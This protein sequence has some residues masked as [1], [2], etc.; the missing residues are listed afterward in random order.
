ME[1]RR[2]GSALRRGAAA[3]AVML[4][5]AAAPAGAA[6][7]PYAGYA[8]TYFTGEGFADGEQV[9][10]ALSQ[11]NDPLR[12]SELNGGRPALTSTLGENGVRDPF[13]VR[14]PDGDRFFLIATDLKIHGNGNWDRAQRFGSRSIMVWESTDLVNWSAQR[15]VQVS[16]P[17]AGNT[18]APEAFWDRASQRYVVFWASALYDNPEHSGSSYQRIMYA[19]TRDFR[20]FSPARTYLDPGYAVIDTTMIEHD[21][22]IY[23]FTKDER[24]N[25]PATPNGKFVF[26]DVGDSVFDSSFQRVTEGIG[27]GVISRGEGPTV[28]KSNTEEKWYLFIDEFGGR[29][30]VPFE[31]TDLDSGQ[32]TLSPDYQLPSRPR[33]GT[34]LPVTQLETDRLAVTPP[35]VCTRTVTGHVA[36]SLEVSSGVTC[37]QEADVDGRVTVSGGASLVVN[38]GSVDGSLTG[39]GAGVVSVIGATL[40]GAVT[41]DGTTDWLRVAASRVGG[42]MSVTRS[43]G[44]VAPD[45]S[46]TSVRGSLSCAGNATAPVLAGTTVSGASSGQCAR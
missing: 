37:L 14:S 26:E 28:F 38:G 33:H 43:G 34:V 24:A 32:W 21:G 44:P 42:S 17:E 9:Y 27:K 15:S 1:L 20:T 35:R 29:G 18:W 40:R 5:V 31:T 8:F 25:T 23:R 3:T 11:G 39:S 7:P 13:I 36:G 45:L 10:F 2:F 19:T 30:Y 12:W 16:P 4:A 41:L 6:E 22:R 46:A